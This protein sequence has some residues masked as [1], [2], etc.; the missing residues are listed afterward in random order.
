MKLFGKKQAALSLQD[1]EVNSAL[2]V[3]SKIKILFRLGQK[4]VAYG[5]I[6]KMTNGTSAT[7]FSPKASLD[8]KTLATLILRQLGYEVS[9]ATGWQQAATTLAE[10]AGMDSLAAFKD[11]KLNQDKMYGVAYYSLFVEGKMK[12][13]IKMLVM[14]NVTVDKLKLN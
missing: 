5:V 13:F 12:N 7:T 1:T 8:G 14:M 3:F 6:N 9:P 4:Y 10:K 2:S 11:T